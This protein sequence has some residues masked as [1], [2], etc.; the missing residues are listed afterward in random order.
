MDPLDPELLC[1]CYQLFME[2]TS[3]IVFK[4]VDFF[5]T[6]QTFSATLTNISITTLFFAFII[7]YVQRNLGLTNLK[8][9]GPKIFFFIPINTGGGEAQSARTLFIRVL[10]LFKVIPLL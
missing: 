9:G 5:K 3:G 10:V 2:F 6:V 8:G 7:F 4:A 1:P